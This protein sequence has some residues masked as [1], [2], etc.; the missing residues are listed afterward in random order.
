[1]HAIRLA[2]R[3]DA[4]T[5]AAM[6]RELVESGLGWSWTPLRVRRSIADR[7]TNVIV[8][9]ADGR[10]AGFALM[11][12]LEEHA[13]LLLFAVS[14]DVRRSG[15]GSAMWQW[16]E[17]TAEVAGVGTVHLEVRAQNTAARDFYRAMG[18][19]DGE[20]VRGYYRGVEAAMRMRRRIS[21]LASSDSP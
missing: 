15:V 2:R 12:Y 11:K 13:H 4:G 21:H 3:A 17:R 8:V 14:A 6:S 20:T 10:V 9:E 18:F 1:M 19:V 16:L 5:I 7:E